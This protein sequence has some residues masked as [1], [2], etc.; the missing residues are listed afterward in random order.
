[1]I[2]VLI[3]CYWI[4]GFE[5]RLSYLLAVRLW[6][7]TQTL[8]ASVSSF[9]IWGWNSQHLLT[10][11]FWGLNNVIYIKQLQQSLD[12]TTSCK[13]VN[14]YFYSLK[15]AHF[16]YFLS[17]GAMLRN[18]QA[19]PYWILITVLKEVSRT[20]ILQMRRL[21]FGEICNISMATLDSN[22]SDSKSQ[23]FNHYVIFLQ[24]SKPWGYLVD[25][26]SHIYS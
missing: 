6:L 12:H 10:R 4:E 22:L 9:V 15:I 13:C 20:P 21:S 19:L 11:F 3:T 16:G 1:M 23:A 18:L 14:C 17:S 26:I 2:W 5:P 7:V 25:N 8:C 24:S